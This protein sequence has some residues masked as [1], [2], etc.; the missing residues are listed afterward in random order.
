MK[1]PFFF[2]RSAADDGRLDSYKRMRR[3]GRDLNMALAKRLPKDAVPEFG[4]KLG[5]FKAGTLILNN[6]DEIAV[7][8]D[9]CLYHY[10]RGN[11]NVIER[12]LEQSPPAADSLDM[13]LL[14]AMLQSRFS[15]FRIVS[16]TP[17]QGA[18]LLDLVRGDTLELV[19]L[20][21]AETGTVGTIL[22]GRL[23]PLPDFHMSTGTLIP[24]SEGEFAGSIVPIIEKFLPAGEDGRRP[25]MSATQ[26]ASYVGRVVKETLRA[27]GMENVFYS[28]M[29]RVG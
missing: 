28:D 2:K 25:A 21:I 9:Y 18:V 13:T 11:K 4:K 8:Y 12:F 24:L 22:V 17:R 10:R 1:W 20:G 16:I 5:L 27:G 26:E 7:L 29:E 14:Q 3:A 19:D 23:L 15:A 6:D